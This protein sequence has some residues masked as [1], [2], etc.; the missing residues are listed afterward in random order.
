MGEEELQNDWDGDTTI[1]TLCLSGKQRG[2]E[3]PDLPPPGSECLRFRPRRNDRSKPEANAY[4]SFGGRLAMMT[5]KD[6]E[7]RQTLLRCR[8]TDNTPRIPL[9][10]YGTPATEGYVFFFERRGERERDQYCTSFIILFFFWFSMGDLGRDI[11]CMDGVD[12]RTVTDRGTHTK[13]CDGRTVAAREGGFLAWFVTYIATWLG[14]R[15]C[16][17]CIWSVVFGFFSLL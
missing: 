6:L 10:T 9:S 12:G 14:G 7:I 16:F 1:T 3:A 2:P 15:N 17:C 13:A 8:R 5:E 11:L 4:R